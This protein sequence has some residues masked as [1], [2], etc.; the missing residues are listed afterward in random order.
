MARRR[1]HCGRDDITTILLF[2]GS[3]A[4]TYIR[5]VPRQRLLPTHWPFRSNCD[6]GGRRPEVRFAS[7]S[8]HSSG[9][10]GS[11]LSANNGSRRHH[12]T[13]SSASNCIE[14]GSSRP[15]AFAA[16]RLITNSNLVGWMIGRSAGLAPLRI[17][18]RDD[19]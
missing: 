5:A 11:P 6:I 13:S 14:L 16:F 17:W 3:A 7:E 15:S 18:W 9:G 10:S 19:R 4:T 2:T 12:S 8:R 1:S